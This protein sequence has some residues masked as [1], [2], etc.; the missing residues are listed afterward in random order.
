MKGDVD[1][2]GQVAFGEGLPDA[3]IYLAATEEFESQAQNLDADA[4]EF[5]PTPS[6]AFT[7]ITV[8]TPTMSGVLR[9]L[10]E[11]ALHRSED[12]TELG[13]VAAS[14]LSDIADILEGWS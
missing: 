14:R 12:A 13:F 11:L 10:E 6:D 7:A 8:M 4:Q 2:D 5:E 3:D 9:G 1:G